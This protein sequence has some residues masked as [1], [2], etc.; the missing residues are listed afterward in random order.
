MRSIRLR[1]QYGRKSDLSFLKW[2]KPLQKC[3]LCK[4]NN[5]SNRKKQPFLM[6]L[7]EPVPDLCHLSD[8]EGCR[9]VL[10]Y[11][12]P[13]SAPFRHASSAFVWPAAVFL[14][15][16]SGHSVREIDTFS[17]SAFNV[18]FDSLR[19]PERRFFQHLQRF[20]LLFL[21]T[22]SRPASE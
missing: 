13:I 15:L 3:L 1:R 14:V 9:C 4:E 7:E 17:R 18:F 10:S 6:L 16:S 20:L 8:T 22:V 2:K 21:S 11:S 5:I 12:F 19:N